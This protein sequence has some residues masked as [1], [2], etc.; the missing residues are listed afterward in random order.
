MQS[1]GLLAKKRHERAQILH[2]RKDQKGNVFYLL[3]DFKIVFPL[4]LQWESLFFICIHTQFWNACF[5][6]QNSEIYILLCK[7]EFFSEFDVTFSLSFLHRKV[8]PL[9]HTAAISCHSD[10]MAE[11]NQLFQELYQ[12]TH[13]N[14]KEFSPFSTV[15]LKS[16]LRKWD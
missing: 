15:R 2:N 12:N 7:T 14:P 5:F 16:R 1:C 8:L 6:E 3:Q 11:N 9:L 13:Y 4:D 10:K